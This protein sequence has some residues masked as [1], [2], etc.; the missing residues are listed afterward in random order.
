MAVKVTKDAAGYRAAE[1]PAS[2]SCRTCLAFM[3]IQRRCSTVA[4]IISAED[5]CD[6]WEARDDG[7]E[8]ARSDEE[9]ATRRT[10]A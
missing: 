5:T 7:K 8:T 10:A 2:R 1:L 4:G 9:P 6:E 3:P